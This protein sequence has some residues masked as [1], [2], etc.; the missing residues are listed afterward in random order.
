MGGK[1]SQLTV[2]F[3]LVIRDTGSHEKHISPNCA[4]SI[5]R[6]EITQSNCDNKA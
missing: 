6:T 5:N 1:E 2:Y 4:R 3:H